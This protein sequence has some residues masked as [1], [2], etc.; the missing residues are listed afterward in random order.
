MSKQKQVSPYNKIRS[1]KDITFDIKRSYTYESDKAGKELKLP[2]VAAVASEKIHG[3]NGAVGYNTQDGFWVQKRSGVCT[4]TKD[5]AGCAKFCNDREHLW[6]DLILAIA[7]ENNVN[8]DESS[9]IIYFEFCGGNIQKNSAVSSLEKR[10]IVFQHCKIKSF[11]EEI[12]SKWVETRGM[13]TSGRRSWLPADVEGSHDIYN[14]MKFKNW[15]FKIDF[16]DPNATVKHLKTIVEDE[17][18]PNSPL[19]QRMG[20]N[21]N[22]G[23][24]VVVTFKHKGDIIKF[25]AKG[26]KHS[27]SKVTKIKEFAMSS[28]DEKRCTEFAN[29]YATA[30]RMEQML[31][32]LYGVES[33]KE[34]TKKDT[35][36]FLGL[37]IK[38]IMEEEKYVDA[39][40]KDLDSKIV[41]K[42]IATIAKRW[43]FTQVEKIS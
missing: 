26:E 42:F 41:N 33:D 25:K 36:T 30:S 29:K 43:F 32:T 35:G 16:S 8:L 12:P 38:D 6:M 24:G 7:K 3:T 2:T 23:E 19:G 13:T 27:S 9:I 4:I 10:A 39:D 40:G 15:K 17:I 28:E 21:E 1:F 5:N 31:Q 22:I 14:I 20:V 37:V 18:E 11:D 34:P